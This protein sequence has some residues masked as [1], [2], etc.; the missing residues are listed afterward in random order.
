MSLLEIARRL[1]RAKSPKREGPAETD[2]IS[3][4][5]RG[6]LDAVRVRE[7]YF[8]A[9]PSRGIGIDVRHFLTND[10][11]RPDR[12]VRD[13]GA[14][15]RLSDKYRE[16]TDRRMM[17]VGRHCSSV[18][19]SENITILACRVLVSMSRITFDRFSAKRVAF[20]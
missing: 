16:I 7:N 18:T 11:K 15:Q 2:A 12:I 17:A 8:R 9:S 5:S 19:S 14:V 1:A 13:D 20:R 3:N 10:Y 6:P 4:G